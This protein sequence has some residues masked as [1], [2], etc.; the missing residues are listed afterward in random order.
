M[1][2]LLETGKLI[3][4][5]RKDRSGRVVRISKHIRIDGTQKPVSEII[6]YPDGSSTLYLYNET[7]DGMEHVFR[8][9]KTSAGPGSSLA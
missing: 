5:V 2:M 1:T 8:L 3:R 9:D 7:G 4:V 6:Y